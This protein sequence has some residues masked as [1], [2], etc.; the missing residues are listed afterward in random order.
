MEARH[1]YIVDEFH[2]QSKRNMLCVLDFVIS[3]QLRRE[4]CGKILFDKMLKYE[5]TN[6]YELAYD[7]PSPKM[8]HFMAKQYLLNYAYVQ[9]NRYVFFSAGSSKKQTE[10]NARICLEAKWYNEHGKRKVE[11][12]EITRM[13]GN[14]SNWRN[15]L[16]LPPMI[17]VAEPIV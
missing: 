15:S 12:P 9:P 14:N 7:R 6:A 13:S 2:R 1:L 10:P 11:T 3:S 16:I 4:G 5:N 8:V 17:T